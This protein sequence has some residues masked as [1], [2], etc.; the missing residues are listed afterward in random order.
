MGRKRYGTTSGK[1]AP[2][3]A[4]KMAIYAINISGL[5][6][7]DY[8]IFTGPAHYANANVE[9]NFGRWRRGGNGDGDIGA[10]NGNAK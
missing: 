1:K 9:V 6:F 4:P 3:L 7:Y 8:P 10:E 5:E 2:K